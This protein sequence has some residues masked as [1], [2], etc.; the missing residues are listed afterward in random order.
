M[1]ELS[2]LL[3]AQEASTE[4]EDL[5]AAALVCA[6]LGVLLTKLAGLAGYRSLLSRALAL[7]RNESP[8]MAE[9]RIAPD[10]SLTGIDK[11]QTD[12][13]SAEQ[14]AVGLVTQLLGLLHTFIGEALTLQ[15]VHEAWPDIS[16]PP[17]TAGNTSEG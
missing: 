16:I 3:L 1:R 4:G 9:V 5:P 10:G 15:L 7:A 6:K 13:G 17:A 8:G 14:G 2:A 12:P 11:A